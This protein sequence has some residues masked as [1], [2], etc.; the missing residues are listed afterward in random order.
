MTD[1]VPRLYPDAWRVMDADMARPDPLRL[2]LAEADHLAL[3]ASYLQ[4]DHG[5]PLSRWVAAVL[6]D[7]R[8]GARDR[9]GARRDPR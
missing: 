7:V 3:E 5:G 6:D 4:D 8:H 2:T 9:S 1:A